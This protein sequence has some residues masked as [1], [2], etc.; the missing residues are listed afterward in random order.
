MTRHVGLAHDPNVLAR[1]GFAYSGGDRA[2]LLGIRSKGVSGLQ[3]TQKSPRRLARV[4]GF[5]EFAIDF[6]PYLGLHRLYGR[7]RTCEAELRKVVAE[8]G[9]ADR[10][11]RFRPGL[12]AC[13][14]P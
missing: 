6:G 10:G 9:S 2:A 3:Y 11:H 8:F 5:D 4:P 12:L 1:G 14:W 7:R 13:F